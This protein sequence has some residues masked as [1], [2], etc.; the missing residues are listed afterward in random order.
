MRRLLLIALSYLFLS[1]PTSDRDAVAQEP[2]SR[3]GA[4]DAPSDAHPRSAPFPHDWRKLDT[5]P[6]RGK[7]D[8]ICFVNESIGWYVNGAGKIFKTID[9]GTSWALQL[10]QPGTFFRCVAFVD[11]ERGFAGNIGPGYFPNVTDPVALYQTLDGGSTWSAIQ[12]I[13]GEPVV[14][15]C[16]LQ[17]IKEEFINAGQLDHRTRIVGVGRVGGPTAM[18]VSDDLGATWQQ[19]SI[20]EH[21]AMAFDVHFWNRNVGFIAAASDADVSQS[22]AV[23][24]MTQDGGKSWNRVWQSSR[25]YELT[26]KISFPSRDVGFVTIQSYNPDPMIAERFVAKTI[27]GGK[28]WTEIPLISDPKVR[29]FG[30][31]FLDEKRGWVGATPNGFQTLDGGLTWE[32][33]QMG[34]AVNKIRLLKTNGGYVGYAIGVDVHRIDVPGEGS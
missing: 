16:A 1:V 9:G 20:R 33:V 17:V 12:T 4:T 26:W 2:R 15:L 24:L 28:T 18:I 27:D 14:G 3:E 13:D 34:N 5:E 19:V 7:Q 30:I 23:I 31:G 29:E 6:Y 11:E 10:H 32:R 8:D 22:N 21:A 25:P